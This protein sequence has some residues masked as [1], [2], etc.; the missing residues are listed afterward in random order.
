MPAVDRQVSNAPVHLKKSCLLVVL[1]L[2]ANWPGGTHGRFDQIYL[3]KEPGTHNDGIDVAWN[4]GSGHGYRSRGVL[5]KDRSI[6]LSPAGITLAA[7]RRAQGT[8]PSLSL[9]EWDRPNSLLCGGDWPRWSAVRRVI[10]KKKRQPSL[11]ANS[12]L[13][14]M[15]LP[16]IEM[17]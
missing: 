6:Q 5:S 4:D 8:L 15:V 14:A 3:Q 1:G 12:C 9:G 2:L 16:R 11:M 13:G 7:A 10:S 17:T